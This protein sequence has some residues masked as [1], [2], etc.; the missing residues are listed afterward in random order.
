[1]AIKN[2]L[3]GELSN[4]QNSVKNRDQLQNMVND[5]LFGLLNAQTD[6]RIIA[7][8]QFFNQLSDLASNGLDIE[9]EVTSINANISNRVQTSA[10]PPQNALTS[11]TYTTNSLSEIATTI[12]RVAAELQRVKLTKINLERRIAQKSSELSEANKNQRTTQ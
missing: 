4:I 7:D 12:Q 2:A 5:T 6:R 10:T 11:V 9:A 8:A 1:M 3:K